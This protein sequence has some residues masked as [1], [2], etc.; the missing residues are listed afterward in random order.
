LFIEPKAG[1]GED[2]ETAE[3]VI[4]ENLIPESVVLLQGTDEFLK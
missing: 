2:E 4:D 1:E 3:K